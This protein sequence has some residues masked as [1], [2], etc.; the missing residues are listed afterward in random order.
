LPLNFITRFLSA[1]YFKQATN[2][3]MPVECTMAENQIVKAKSKSK[4]IALVAVCIA[5]VLVAAFVGI[6]YL[7]PS[8]NQQIPSSNIA[9]NFSDGA[10]LNFAIVSYDSAGNPKGHGI[11]N[12]TI[13]SGIYS[14][15]PCWIYTGN[16]TFTYN[17]GTIFKDLMTSYYDKSTFATLQMSQVRYANGELEFNQ[18]LGPN[19]E[20]FVN[21]LEYFRSLNVTAIHEIISVPAG[22]FKCTV[23]EGPDPEPSVYF[24]IWLSKD[25]PA[26]GEVKFQYSSDEYTFC[27]YTLESF[28][29]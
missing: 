8:N 24:T 4:V 3:H 21:D 10:W 12:G 14:E 23:R 15:K 13:T 20:G 27:T 19:D 29:Y 28:G 18:T 25:V 26:W 6:Y 1:N 22:T 17:N 7:L 16:I 5:I 11:E 9:P 2:H